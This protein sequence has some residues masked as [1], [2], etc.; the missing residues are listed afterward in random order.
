MFGKKRREPT[1]KSIASKA[2]AM[3]NGRAVSKKPQKSLVEPTADGLRVRCKQEIVNVN[4][5]KFEADPR[6]LI[7]IV[8]SITMTIGEYKSQGNLQAEYVIPALRKA[9]SQ[10]VSDLETHFRITWRINDQTGKSEFMQL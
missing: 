10:V 2:L 5:K 4:G 3:T 1:T 8:K 6:E 7:R 9:R